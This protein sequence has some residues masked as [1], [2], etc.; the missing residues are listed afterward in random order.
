MSKDS[1]IKRTAKE[2]FEIYKMKNIGKILTD[3]QTN[4]QKDKHNSDIWLLLSF[5]LLV[6]LC[7]PAMIT[8][9]VGAIL[10][11]L[12]VTVGYLYLR[13]NGRFPASD[14]ERFSLAQYAMG[15]ILLAAVNGKFFYVRWIDSS[16]VEQ[17][18]VWLHMSGKMLVVL[19]DIVLIL[20]AGYS[21]VE[22]WNRFRTWF[23]R[24]S[25]QMKVFVYAAVAAC[26]TNSFPQ[27]MLGVEV[28]GMGAFKFSIG[29]LLI[30]TCTVLLFAVTG[31]GKSSIAAT[32]ILFTILGTAN[33]YVYSFRA[34]MLEP[35]DFMSIR[36]A[37]NVA[38]NYSLFPIPVAIVEIWCVIIIFTMLLWRENLQLERTVIKRMRRISVG[39]GLILTVI[40]TVYMLN[41]QTEHW[42]SNGAVL[43]GYYL[44]FFAKI[45]EIRVREPDDYQ[46]EE[47]KLLSEQYKDSSMKGDPPHIIVVMDESF[48]DLNVVGELKTNID[49]AP[50]ISNLRENTIT[51][52]A[53]A[54]VFGGNTANSEWEFLTG[55]SM[56][57]LPTNTIPYQQY[58]KED[59]Y[60][61][62]SYLKQQYDYECIAMHPFYSSGWNRTSAYSCLGFDDWMFLEDF[63]GQKLWRA[64]VTDEELFEEM[65]RV[66]EEKKE[67]PLFLFGI[68]MQNHGGYG[69]VGDHYENTVY[70]KDAPGQY[71]KAEQYLS[72]IH[73][74]DQAVEM[75]VE[76]F[77]KVEEDV[78]IVFFGDHFPNLESEF[79]EE[80][81]EGTFDSLEEQQNRYKVP[82]FVWA[83]YDIEERTVECT[84]INYL[85][86]FMYEA[87][88]I[89]L[90]PYGQFLN[91]LQKSVPAMNANGFYSASRASFCE[92]EGQN[93]D[94]EKW[95]SLYEQLQYNAVFDT[96]NRLSAFFPVVGKK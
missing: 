87:A 17:L 91:D 70:L 55:N 21:V 68:T 67:N 43:N 5:Y 29:M 66:F 31:K 2:N 96:D 84:S 47:L 74:T 94:E 24:Q 27:M 3:K 62:V 16:K 52:Y 76:Y 34:V 65:I 71:P 1:K 35:L 15:T 13:H 22:I 77:K 49:V 86:N 57:W 28:F 7:T 81:N 95:L 36:T 38:A 90:P 64:Y 41:L 4:R 61:V 56:A 48:A 75:L 83:N 53:L 46:I 6:L 72:C 18:A 69:Y 32:M 30:F 9:I 11:C 37:W 85:S 8:R 73:E 39:A 78:V 14:R 59:S 26:L 12:C 20:G 40:L 19:A 93:A 88:G 42:Q 58:M 60:S 25:D 89:S 10:L 23:R 33:T 51:G 82:F 45:K 80:L 92:Y 44:D 54:S 63:P 50:Y 79:Y